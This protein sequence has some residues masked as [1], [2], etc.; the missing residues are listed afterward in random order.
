MSPAELPRPLRRG[1]AASQGAGPEKTHENWSCSWENHGKT[2]GK[3]PNFRKKTELFMGTMGK[4]CEVT[5]GVHGK[6]VGKPIQELSV[7]ETHR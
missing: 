7:L 5:G 3:S 2:V 6:I 4:F 1:R